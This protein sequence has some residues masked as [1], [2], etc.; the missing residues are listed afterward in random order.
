MAGRYINDNLDASALNCAFVK[1]R[2]ERKALVKCLR[3]IRPGEEARAARRRCPACLPPPRL[4]AAFSPA[5]RAMQVDVSSL[6]AFS[7]CAPLQLYASY[8]ESYWAARK[9][10]AAAGDPP[11]P[12]GAAA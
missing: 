5:R 2:A 4:P 6:R 1:L 9:Q 7:P 3:D 8:G 11:P 10:A 12:D